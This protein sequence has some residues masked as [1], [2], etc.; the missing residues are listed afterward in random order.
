MRLEDVYGYIGMAS[1][2][3]RR[4]VTQKEI[5]VHFKGSLGVVNY[6]LRPLHRIGAIRKK[7]RGFELVDWRKFLVHWASA[8]RT[9]TG[10]STHSAEPV[11]KI[12]GQMPPVL[13]TAYS[14]AKIYHGVNPSDY[15]E[16]F[17]YADCAVIRKRFPPAGG[18]PNIFCRE[19]PAFLEG[20]KAVPLTLLYVDLWNLGT[21]YAREFLNAVEVKLNGILE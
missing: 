1:E 10:Y 20:A 14:G 16:C 9:K 4:S 21:W 13:F 19:T 17:V 18:R 2:S 7:T 12:E 15:S 5:A 6:A 11:E 3:G 8:R